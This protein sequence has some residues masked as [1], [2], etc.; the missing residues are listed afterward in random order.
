M[1]LEQLSQARVTTKVQAQRWIRNAVATIGNGWHPDDSAADLINTE[2]R[3]PTFTTE[4]AL[5]V[6]DIVS[7]CFKL[8]GTKVYEIG[9]KAQEANA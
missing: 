3:L 6:D 8:L 7:K 5:K 2:T 4:Q 9:A 1:T